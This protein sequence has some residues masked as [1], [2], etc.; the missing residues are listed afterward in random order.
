MGRRRKE[1]PGRAGENVGVIQATAIY[2]AAEAHRLLRIGRKV[3]SA[4]V[5]EGRIAC[6][7]HG[8]RQLFEGRWLLD[9]V[10][11]LPAQRPENTRTTAGQG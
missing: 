5:R 9:W 3:L 1:I 11:K 8:P 6:R 10:E 4:E 7:W 2:T